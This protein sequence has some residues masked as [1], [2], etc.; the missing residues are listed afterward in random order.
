MSASRSPRGR[1]AAQWLQ[2]IRDYTTD[3]AKGVPRTL[4]PRETSA[5]A[6]WILFLTDSMPEAID[7]DCPYKLCPLQVDD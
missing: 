2:W 5:I 1:S 7:W 3:C 6:N 4:D